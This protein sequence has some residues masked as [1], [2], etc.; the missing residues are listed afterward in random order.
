MISFTSQPLYRKE[1]TPDAHSTGGGAAWPPSGRFWYCA[2][3]PWV[4]EPVA[5]CTYQMKYT[6]PRYI[7]QWSTVPYCFV[8]LLRRNFPIANKVNRDTKVE[9]FTEI[10]VLGP[11]RKMPHFQLIVFKLCTKKC[12][13]NATTC[14][15]EISWFPSWLWR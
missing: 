4:V 9:V 3:L 7:P 11:L 8:C 12:S 6:G 2:P 10:Q 1:G 13:H 5:P 14:S 15:Y